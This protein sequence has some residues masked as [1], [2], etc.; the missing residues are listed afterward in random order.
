[1]RSL[2]KIQSS[3]LTKSSMKAYRLEELAKMTNC[4]LFGDPTHQISGIADL[5]SATSS[6]ASFLTNPRYESQMLQSNAGVIVI[7][8]GFEAASCANKNFLFS[9]HPDATFQM[10]IELFRSHLVSKSEFRGI[11]PSAVIHP[12]AQIGQDVTICPF[13]VIDGR[14]VIG[15]GT[16]IGPHTSIGP[17][18]QIGESCVV[19]AHVTIREGCVVGNR[20]TLQPGAVIGSCGFGYTSDKQG[21]HCKLNQLGNVV[22]EDDV[23]IGANTTIDRAR[24]KSTRIEQGTKVD[25]LVQI[26]H[27]VVIGKHSLIIAQSG[28][29]GSASIGNHV[30]LA[31]KVAVNGHIKIADQVMVAAC[32]AVTKSIQKPGK[33]GGFP[34]QELSEHNKNQ[35]QLRNISKFVQ[36]LR[37]LENKVNSIFK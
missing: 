5:E 3:R 18:V 30:I 35:V 25:N 1:M 32:S 10:L 2:K 34:V 6:D 33:Y 9:Q 21:H 27:G 4:R 14:V 17:G 19:H 31:G 7:K 28:I 22:L 15:Q 12:S 29:A 36:Q 11:H 23:E 24:F 8:E 16:S 13:V 20:V 37:D 26:A